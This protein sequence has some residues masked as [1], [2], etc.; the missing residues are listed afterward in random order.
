MATKQREQALSVGKGWSY[1]DEGARATLNPP[2]AIGFSHF[3]GEFEQ[4]GASQ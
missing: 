3:L 1:A 2:S 4:T